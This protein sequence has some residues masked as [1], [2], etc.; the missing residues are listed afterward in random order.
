MTTSLNMDR[1]DRGAR[2]QDIARR[3]GVS[4]P[5]VWQILGGRAGRYRPET[6]QMVEALAKELGYRPNAGALAISRGRFR[7]LAMVTSVVS[8]RSVWAGGL[9][10]G[11]HRR[12][13]RDDYHLV[14]SCLADDAL[15]AEDAPPKL[16][17]EQM[18][19]GLLLNYAYQV[20]AGLEAALR[21]HRIPAVWIN[22]QLKRNAAYPDDE[23]AGRA[24]TEAMLAAGHRRIVYCSSHSDGHFSDAARAAGNAAAMRRAGL[25]PRE[26]RSNGVSGSW[27][28]QLYALLAAPERPTAL[29]AYSPHS[30]YP[31][32]A[33]AATLGLS[34]PRDLS[35]ATFADRPANDAGFELSTWLVPFAGVGEAAADLAL[36]LV[37]G[38]RAQ[39]SRRIP[40][41][42]VSGASIAPAPT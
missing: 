3:A 29:L 11:L 21:R 39:T 33:V 15:V 9:W 34:L 7:C 28:Q 31:V 30:A 36:G 25:Q 10:E 23:G 12:L 4:L 14:V 37:A 1:K 41:T 17:R 42:E 32:S 24:A 13:L 18:A 6:R 2:A 16:L 8:S 19:D 40:F 27:S 20:P 26:L 5:T 38:T 35:L 22:R